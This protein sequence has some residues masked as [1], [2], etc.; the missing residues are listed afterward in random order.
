[1]ARGVQK[2]RRAGRPPAGAHPGEKVSDYPQVS[3]RI[4]PTLKSQL[5]ALSILR[6]KPQWRILIEALECVMRELPESDKRMVRDI[7]T[8]TGK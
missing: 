2:R 3:L 8:R 6:S 5:Y 1:M 7:A 4:P